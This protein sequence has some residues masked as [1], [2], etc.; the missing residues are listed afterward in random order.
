MA[1]PAATFT[2]FDAIG[3]REDLADIVYN[4]APTETP[5]MMSVGRGS[6]SS[7]KHEWQVDTL[8]AH[9]I[10]AVAEGDEPAT[11]TAS[12]ATDRL[13][14][15][16]QISTKTLTISGTQ[17]AVDKAGRKSE[18]AYQLAKRAKELKRDC[19]ANLCGITNSGQANALVL[20]AAEGT[21]NVLASVEQWLHTNIDRNGGTAFAFTLN[22][23]DNNDTSAADGTQR[24]LL[25]STLKTVIQTTWNEGGEPSLI[26]TG[27]VNKQNLSAFTG[28]ATRF[29][30]SEDKTLY[31][32]VDIYVSD[33]GSHNVMPNR[34]SRDRT[35]FLLT[36]SLWSVDYLRP[37][38]QFP[39]AKV[40]DTE[41]RELLVEYT[42]R[43]SNEKGSGAVF[44]LTT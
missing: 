20:S 42:L 29:D 39:L 23:P 40:G 34:F 36:P 6:A 41:R 44:D 13:F 26:M 18:L 38:N 35:L 19:E 17:E 1:V 10:N 31:T 16:L 11:L 27:P 37:F 24:A 2:T 15:A 22:Q 12:V 14:N 9:A 25:E 3:N 5:L 8:A 43:S 33:F 28:N 30:K 32:S 4:I 21:A 7:V